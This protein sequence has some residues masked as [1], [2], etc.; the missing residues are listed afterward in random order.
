LFPGIPVPGIPGK[1]QKILDISGKS[2]DFPGISR[3]FPGFSA[4]LSLPVSREIWKHYYEVGSL[5]LKA[6]ALPR[7]LPERGG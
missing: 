7:E 2:R 6:I 4:F 3:E 5:L 1:S